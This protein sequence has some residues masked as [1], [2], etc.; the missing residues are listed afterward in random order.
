[1]KSYDQ[2]EDEAKA[3]LKKRPKMRVSGRS[4]FVLQKSASKTKKK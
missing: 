3:K 1:M 4:V 2:I